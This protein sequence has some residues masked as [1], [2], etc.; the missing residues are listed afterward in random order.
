[1]TG[2]RLAL[3]SARDIPVTYHGPIVAGPYPPAEVTP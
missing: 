3:V 1:M 2:P